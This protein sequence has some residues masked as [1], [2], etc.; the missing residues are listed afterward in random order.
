VWLASYI[1]LVTLDPGSIAKKTTTNEEILNAFKNGK[2]SQFC[3]SCKCRKPIRSKHCRSSDLCVAR[4]DH[5]C[6]WIN[7]AVGLNNHRLFLLVLFGICI[8]HS[9]FIYFCYT[10]FSSQ[11]INV[12][13]W[14]LFPTLYHQHPIVFEIFL[15]H[16]LVA[17][18]NWY[19]C[20]YT[21]TM[22]LLNITTNENLNRR[23]YK[24]LW[25]N[26]KFH[27]QF[28][29]GIISNLIEFIFSTVDYTKTF[30]SDIIDV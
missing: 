16:I 23:R 14:S 27:N 11:S 13:Y 3:M 21:T 22:V 8:N 7:N 15:Y 6:P 1:R 29:K 5:F 24:Y 17:C 9:L 18:W 10:Y 25:L 20:F 30:E 12:S 19:N 26:S 4:F 28:D 2:A